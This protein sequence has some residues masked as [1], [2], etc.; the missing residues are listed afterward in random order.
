MTKDEFEAHCAEL[1][2]LSEVN[3]EANKW[4]DAFTTLMYCYVALAYKRKWKDYDSGFDYKFAAKQVIEEVGLGEIYVDIKGEI[5]R[6]E[7]LL[8]REE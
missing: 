6:L 7:Y 2:K 1:E 3:G 5:P 4:K 8:D